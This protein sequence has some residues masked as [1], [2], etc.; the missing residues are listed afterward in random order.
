MARPPLPLGDHG[1][2]TVTRSSS[3]WIAR[4]RIRDLDGRTRKLERWGSTRTAANSSLQDAQRERRGV[5]KAKPLRPTSKFSEAA[6][7]WSTKVAER[8]E[9]STSD[10]A[11]SL[12]TASRRLAALV[13]DTA[14]SIRS[15]YSS[16]HDSLRR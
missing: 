15:W 12:A 11:A 10:T 2:I 8:R 5:E 3:R 4:C 13:E 7:I 1:S 6:D 16:C 9:D 14:A